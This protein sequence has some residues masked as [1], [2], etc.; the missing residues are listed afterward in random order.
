MDRITRVNITDNVLTDLRTQYNSA[1]D[2]QNGLWSSNATYSL[3]RNTIENMRYGIKAENIVSGRTFKVTENNFQNNF[4][5]ISTRAVDNFVTID[6]DFVIGG[7][8]GPTTEFDF[9]ERQTGMHVD[10]SSGFFIEDNDFVA[11]TALPPTAEP[12]GLA[13]NNTNV[14]A[15]GELN[16]DFNHAFRN[17]FTEL[18]RANIANGNNGGNN[19]MGGFR[20]FCNTNVDN[21]CTD[22]T[23]FDGT[24]SPIQRT[25]DNSAVGNTFTQGSSTCT[26]KH[27]DNTGG[28]AIDYHYFDQSN[29]NVEDPTSAPPVI[30]SKSVAVQNQCLND[31]DSPNP[32]GPNG[33]TGLTGDYPVSRQNYLGFR[34]QYYN[35]LDGG[36]TDF[37]LSAI[38]NMGTSSN[39]GVYQQLQQ[40]SPW[41]ST[42]VLIAYTDHV[43]PTANE[44]EALLLVNPDGIKGSTLNNSIQ[45]GGWFTGQQITNIEASAQNTTT[46]TQ[47]E[48]NLRNAQSELQGITRALENYYQIDEADNGL[49]YAN[50]ADWAAN[51]ESLDGY[52]RSIDNRLL[53]GDVT[54]ANNEITALQA[55]DMSMEQTQEIGHFVQLK[56]LEIDLLNTNR[57]YDDATSTE[58]STLQ[59]IV[60]QSSARASVQAQNWLHLL[61]VSEAQ[62]EA[63]WGTSGAALQDNKP[64][65][66]MSQQGRVL[67]QAEYIRVNP[68][69]STNLFRFHFNSQNAVKS[70]MVEIYNMNGQRIHQQIVVSGNWFDWQPNNERAGVYFFAL[71][72]DN[73]AIIQRGKIAYLSD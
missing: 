69:P 55:M 15:A 11:A 24:I 49:D 1:D 22:F 27:F 13:I 12:V 16:S 45:N 38:N 7:F 29:G 31:D 36:D 26:Y 19:F 61:G 68:N 43:A 34:Q 57:E 39:Y 63:Y 4:F 72:D 62:A 25:E 3:K 52:L 46:R 10:Q 53:A 65:S 44:K 41:L 21:E 47:L 70:G 51:G 54:T 14:G 66:T 20:Y 56:N 30:F 5:G 67:T 33:E 17:D 6:N 73:G 35:Q 2:L 58:I 40:L 60:A 32:P 50:Q 37:L 23:V 9:P 48:T 8:T 28:N 71:R 18:Y 64:R 42:D 59:T